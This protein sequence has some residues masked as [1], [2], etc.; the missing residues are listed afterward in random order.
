MPQTESRVQIPR[1]AFLRFER[2]V[3]TVIQEETVLRTFQN[4]RRLFFWTAFNGTRIFDFTAP[5]PRDE[6]Y[7]G[8]RYGGVAEQGLHGQQEF[9]KR[10]SNS[11]NVCESNVAI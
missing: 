8:G 4:V 11:K 9:M 5:V 2:R 1:P 7:G 3:L 10:V 6:I